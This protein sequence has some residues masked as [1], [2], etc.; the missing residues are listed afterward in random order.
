[1][2]KLPSPIGQN[3]AFFGTVFENSLRKI[4]VLAVPL[5]NGLKESVNEWLLR[6]IGM[7]RRRKTIWNQPKNPLVLLVTALPTT[8]RF[9]EYEKVYLLKNQFIR[10][11]SMD[12]L[13]YLK[14]SFPFR[15]PDF[16]KRGMESLWNVSD[17][18]KMQ[19]ALAMTFRNE[20]RA[21]AMFFMR[22]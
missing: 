5:H 12:T 18:D 20:P 1:M 15:M 10:Q 19:A 6:M 17:E 4:V 3:G 13:A 16:K 2:E 8:P 14:L 9:V 22:D 11:E 7:I 21:K